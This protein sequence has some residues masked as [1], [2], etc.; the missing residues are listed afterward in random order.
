M[1]EGPF[2]PPSL[3]LPPSPPVSGSLFSLSPSCALF[4]SSPVPSPP[5]EHP[6][7]SHQATLPCPSSLLPLSGWQVPWARLHPSWPN[8]VTAEEPASAAGGDAVGERDHSN[9]LKERKDGCR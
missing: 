4:P 7:S 9:W 5:S 6:D 3:S 1:L 2:P 8:S